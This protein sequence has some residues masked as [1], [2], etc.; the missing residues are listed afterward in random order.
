MP[1]SLY[2]DFTRKVPERKESAMP[3]QWMKR[4]PAKTGI[5]SF[6]NASR[7][8]AADEERKFMLDKNAWDFFQKQTPSYRRMAIWWIVSAKKEE[9]RARRLSL[10]IEDSA[11]ERT[12]ARFTRSKSS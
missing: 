5:Y 11:S 3:N 8:L 2:L 4:D 12:L 9:T 6:E 7:T 10:L 1:G